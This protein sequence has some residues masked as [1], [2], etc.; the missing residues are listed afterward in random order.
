[1]ATTGADHGDY[2]AIRA[3]VGAGDNA[4]VISP[5]YAIFSNAADHGRRPSAAGAV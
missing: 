2:A 3:C 5:A 1:M 4:I